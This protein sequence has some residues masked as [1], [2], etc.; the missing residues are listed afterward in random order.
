VS[1][2]ATETATPEPPVRVRMKTRK[3]VYPRDH[4]LTCVLTYF[5]GDQWKTSSR[6]AVLHVPNWY[7][8]HPVLTWII[9]VLIAVTGLGLAVARALVDLF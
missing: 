2:I 1:M 5:D 8:R 9:G 4:E 6:N 3:K 7:Q